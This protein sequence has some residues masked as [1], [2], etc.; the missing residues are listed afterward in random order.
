MLI[1]ETPVFTERVLD[2]LTGEEYRKLQLYLTKSPGAGDVIPGSHGLRKLRWKG[3]RRGKRGGTR[4]IYYW[5]HSK[6][7]IEMLFIFKKNEMHDLTRDQLK[8]LQS[9][10]GRELR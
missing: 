1:I 8:V 3:S 9:I 6:D 10:A 5:L 2:I 7:A 4:V